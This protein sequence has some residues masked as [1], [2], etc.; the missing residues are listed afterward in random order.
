MSIQQISDYEFICNDCGHK[1]ILGHQRGMEAAVQTAK[2]LGWSI[3]QCPTCIEPE[4]NYTQADR[5]FDLW[6]GMGGQ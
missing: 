1:M 4:L 5:S 3:D 6:A 2:N